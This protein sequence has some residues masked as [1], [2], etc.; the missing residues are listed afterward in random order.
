MSNLLE[1]AVLAV[2]VT[3]LGA[4]S[5]A[6]SFD[7]NRASTTTEHAVCDYP[8]LSALDDLM[9]QAYLLAKA[10]ADWIAPEELK[11]TQKA[12]AQQRNRCSDNYD[13]LRSSYIQRLEEVSN[14][15]LHFSVGRNSASYVYEGE[16]VSGA[17]PSGTT[18]SDW[19]Q[20]VSWFRG[21]PFFRGVS[22]GGAM[23]FSY[24]YFG[25]NGH[26]CSLSGRADN[27][28]GFWFFKDERST[29]ALR[30]GLG[31]RG[32]SLNPTPECNR[33]CGMRAQGGL[34]QVIPF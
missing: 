8:E 32:L 17:C 7:C 16:P 22:A 20:C 30:I 15:V 18:L 24:E 21:G 27:V 11:N 9:G 12:W 4:S 29:C 6:A 31:P 3:L 5:Y 25:A 34:E 26:M 14:G 28:D 2:A 33:Y 1:T 10:S 23:A 13:C 19:G